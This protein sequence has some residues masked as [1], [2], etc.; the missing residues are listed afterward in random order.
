MHIGQHVAANVVS[1]HAALDRPIRRGD[2]VIFNLGGASQ[3]TRWLML[4]DPDPDRDDPICLRPNMRNVATR[5]RIEPEKWG[6]LPIY[7]IPVD[8]EP[9]Y[10]HILEGIHDREAEVH[11]RQITL[12]VMQAIMLPT[13]CKTMARRVGRI[14]DEDVLWDAARWLLG[15]WVVNPRHPP[16]ATWPQSICHRGILDRILAD[17]RELVRMLVGQ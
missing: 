15:P 2:I 8:N 11:G 7:L 13:W 4:E 3:S 6:R 1:T 16:V 5:L 14:R 9:A 17:S 10:K 12:R